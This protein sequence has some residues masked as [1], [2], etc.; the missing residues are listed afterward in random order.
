MASKRFS[1]E[2]MVCGY[3]VYKDVWEAA[4]EEELR[5]K[6]EPGNRQDSFAMAVMRS[7]VTVDHILKKI[8][9]VRFMFLRQGSAT[10]CQ[11]K[12]S[13]RYSKD[14]PQGGLEIPCTLTFEGYAKPSPLCLRKRS[15]TTERLW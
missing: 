11:V 13:K 12:A 3:H 5:C 1:V 8:S 10:K 6:R 14:L 15:L 9:S 4:V 2:V 7:A